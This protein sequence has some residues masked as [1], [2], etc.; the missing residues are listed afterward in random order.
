[1]RA[2]AVSKPVA[3]TA[4]RYEP[5]PLGPLDDV[6]DVPVAS[7]RLT[8]AWPT[9]YG[10]PAPAVVAT[11]RSAYRG[12]QRCRRHAGWP[13]KACV[14]A[15]AGR[16]SQ[17]SGASLA[18]A[19]GPAQGRWCCAARLRGGSLLR[20]RAS[21]WR[22]CPAHLTP[23]LASPEH[24]RQSAYVRWDRWSFWRSAGTGPAYGAGRWACKAWP[25]RRDPA[26]LPPR[27]AVTAN[28]STAA[29][30]DIA[31]RS[32]AC[33]SSS[34][35][36][37]AWRLWAC[38]TYPRPSPGRSAVDAILAALRLQDAVRSCSH[39]PSTA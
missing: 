8:S 4:A 7:A 3:R 16:A 21:D 36:R 12:R 31:R 19:P 26:G 18:A 39:G 35:R 9:T 2:Y 23:S 6:A 29:K 11:R 28:S 34:S 20:V 14:G 17:V 5:E 22:V 30:V 38:L 15:V 13:G 37:R 25:P 24:A 33:A 10:V 32:G 27:A 1:M